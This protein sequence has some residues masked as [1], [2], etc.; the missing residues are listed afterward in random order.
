MKGNFNNSVE[1]LNNMPP[2]E[3]STDEYAE[4][5]AAKLLKLTKR[6]WTVQL[7][8]LEE[9]AGGGLR[10]SPTESRLIDGSISPEDWGHLQRLFGACPASRRTWYMFPDEIGPAMQ[11]LGIKLPY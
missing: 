1:W 4:K 2:S 7:V 9:K 5:I 10:I 11:V 3:F 8:P 6:E